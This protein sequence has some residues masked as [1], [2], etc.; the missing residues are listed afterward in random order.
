MCASTDASRD[1]AKPTADRVPR[2]TVEYR[3]I[4]PMILALLADPT[5]SREIRE[6]NQAMDAPAGDVDNG[7]R[8]MRD[9]RFKLCRTPLSFVPATAR[10]RARHSRA[11]VHG[12]YWGIGPG[13]KGERAN[14]HRHGRH[15]RNARPPPHAWQHGTL[16][17]LAPRDDSDDEADNDDDERRGDVFIRGRENELGDGTG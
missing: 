9:L 15:G 10:G 16:L 5:S 11:A 2:R 8:L 14:Y 4:L 17:F 1:S 6:W 12:V 13:R 7:R 3:P